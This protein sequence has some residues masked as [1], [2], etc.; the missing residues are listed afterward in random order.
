MDYILYAGLPDLFNTWQ[1][2]KSQMTVLPM[3]L[4]ANYL[5]DSET[6]DIPMGIPRIE[7]IIFKA[8]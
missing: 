4:W 5:Q 3:Q 8:D 2:I 7:T 1:V 6:G